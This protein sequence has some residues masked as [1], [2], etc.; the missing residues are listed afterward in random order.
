M[1]TDLPATGK[2]VSVTFTFDGATVKTYE[3]T[4]HRVEE[5]V[6]RVDTKP[7]GTTKKLIDTVR[8]GWRIRLTIA[9]SRKDTDELIDIIDA[10]E[11]LR[12]PSVMAIAITTKYRDLTS[13]TYVYPDVKRTS[14]GTGARRGEA[15]QTTLEFE[16]GVTRI[17][18]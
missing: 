3:V 14:Y 12:V 4:E 18:A 17:A 11:E 6:E 2:D 7:L 13:K 16:T 8:E 10:A 9:A 5:M 1:D 15:N